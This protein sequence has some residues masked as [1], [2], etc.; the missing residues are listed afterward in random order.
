MIE[1]YIDGGSRGNPGDG[2]VGYVVLK[3]GDE[4]YRYGEK[5]GR[6]TNNV[7]EYS[8]LIGAL[9]YLKKT[10]SGGGEPVIVYSDSEL[11]IMQMTGRYRVKS[12][13]LKPLHGRAA[14][15]LEEMKDVRLVHI[16]RVKNKTADWIVNR[17]LDGREYKT[18][19]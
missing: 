9:E 13:M 19:L 17:V 10:A 1:V 14:K 11:L 6:C 2:A 7:A 3:D 18:D 12:G 16:G 4:A 8:A 5:I 15:L